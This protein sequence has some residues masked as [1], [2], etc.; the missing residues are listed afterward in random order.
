MV[1]GVDNDGRF[2]ALEGAG[3]KWSFDDHET[4]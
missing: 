1:E 3:E 2:H 4:M